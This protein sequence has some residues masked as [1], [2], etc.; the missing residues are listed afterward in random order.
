MGDISWNN[1]DRVDG[2][3]RDS[4]R[5]S[6]GAAYTYNERWKS[7]FGIAYDRSPI[8]RAAERAV[9]LPD[10]HRLWLAVGGQYRFGKSATLDFGY[11]YQRVKSAWIDQANGAGLRLRGDYDASGHVI[12][13]QYNQGF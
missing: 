5:L 11:A 4:W 8:R 7:K 1:W 10:A 3:D 6:W 12:G 9:F 2:Y 13:M